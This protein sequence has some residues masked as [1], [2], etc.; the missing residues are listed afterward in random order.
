MLKKL[1]T[2]FATLFVC[3]S[4]SA[5]NTPHKVSGRVVDA[6]K[7]GLA[8]STIHFYLQSDS[9]RPYNTLSDESGYFEITVPQDNYGVII[10]YLGFET[11]HSP[12]KVK[13]I[14]DTNIGEIVLN[15]LNLTLNE[16]TVVADMIRRKSEGLLVIPQASITTGRSTLDLLSFIPNVW[17]SKDGNI[18]INGKQGTLV[19]VNDRILKLSGNEL[20]DYL[21]NLNAEDIKSIEVVLNAG[22]SHDASA[23]GGI[24]KINLK[25]QSTEGLKGSASF[26]YNFQD[27]T[28]P[29]RSNPSSSLEYRKNKFSAY[30][31]LSY[32]KSKL[33]QENNEFIQYY[34][35]AQ[36]TMENE[37]TGLYKGDHYSARIGGAYDIDEKQ[38][39]GLDFDVTTSPGKEHFETFSTIKS[40]NENTRS[41]SLYNTDNKRHYYNISLNYHIKID[42]I[43]SSLLVVAD[44]LYNKRN[45]KEDNNLIENYADGRGSVS[46]MNSHTLATTNN[47]SV[48]TDLSKYINQQFRLEAG[49]KYSYS[50]IDTDLEYV[51]SNEADLTDRYLYREAVLAGY[52]GAF[53]TYNRFDLSGGLRME[54][55]RLT[56][57]SY[58]N[59]DQDKNQNYTDFFPHADVSFAFDKKKNVM[60]TGSYRRKIS[61][62]GFSQLNPYRMRLNSNSYVVGNPQMKPSYMNEYSL[63]GVLFGNHSLTVGF[64]ETKDGVSQLIVP[65][66]SDKNIILTQYTNMGKELS[67]YVAFSSSYSLLKNWRIMGD[68]VWF[69]SENSYKEYQFNNNGYNIRVNNILTLPYKINAQVSYTHSKMTQS[70]WKLESNGSFDINLSK[71]FMGD[72][73]SASA[74]VTNLLD[75]NKPILKGVTDQEGFVRKS[76][77]QRT[78]NMM[79]TY[80]MTIRYKFQL[81]KNVRATKINAGNQ[82]ERA[83]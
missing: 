76:F 35:E 44:H 81:G 36:R 40:Q 80:A 66:E 59:P 13:V 33:A 15:P 74:S 20:S 32:Q 45:D 8:F 82:E 51:Y 78:G 17:S 77:E 39:I 60:L 11:Y 25:K 55:T 61:R 42:S 70:I 1:L 72:K 2:L 19:M 37:L 41:Y 9:L 18:S 21:S 28:N 62:P 3:V 67:Y 69:R 23:S 14:S 71:T 56:P 58:S 57:K 7:E 38:Y 50:Q 83:R 31:N 65:D 49:G 10:S 27:E 64:S 24:L 12:H 16:V 30:S 34:N 4:L 63:T 46:D 22:A 5:N 48:R 52:L 53:Y 29:T 26:K 6:N 54:N 47:Y 75:N 43:G 79:R 68:F 73:L